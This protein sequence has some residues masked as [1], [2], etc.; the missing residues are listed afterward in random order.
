[1]VAQ[2]AARYAPVVV[3]QFERGAT[4]T[5]VGEDQFAAL[6]GQHRVHECDGRETDDARTGAKG[7]RSG[8]DNL[9]QDHRT[10]DDRMTG[11]MPWQAG[12]IR[13]DRDSEAQACSHGIPRRVRRAML[14]VRIIGEAVN[15]IKGEPG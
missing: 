6:P 9:R 13:W 8:M 12:M 5:V 11:E 4:D 2:V 1:M 7:P 10:R 3:R 14:G 15:D